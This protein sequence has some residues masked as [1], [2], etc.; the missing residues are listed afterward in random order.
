MGEE[1]PG[2]RENDFVDNRKGVIDHHLSK[3]RG[4]TEVEGECYLRC[5]VFKP[6]TVIE[7]LKMGKVDWRRRFEKGARVVQSTFPHV[8]IEGKKT[9]QDL[10]L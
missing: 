5:H 6:P 1:A 7:S 10:G 2:G 3:I 9:S 4:K 8:H